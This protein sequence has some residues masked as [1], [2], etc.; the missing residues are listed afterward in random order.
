MSFLSEKKGAVWRNWK[1]IGVI[2]F[3][4]GF[5]INVAKCIYESCRVIPISKVFEKTNDT[6]LSFYFIVHVITFKLHGLEFEFLDDFVRE[7]VGELV[8]KKFLA[9]TKKIVSFMNQMLHNQ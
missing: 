4:T 3:Q 7:G 1:E 5:C 6:G 9:K 2:S 8:H